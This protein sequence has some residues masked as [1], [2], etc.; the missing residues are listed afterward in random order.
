MKS[1]IKDT[2]KKQRIISTKKKAKYN[3]KK[4]SSIVLYFTNQSDYNNNYK[5]A[6]NRYMTQFSIEQASNVLVWIAKQNRFKI[7]K[8]YF[9]QYQLDIIEVDIEDRYRTRTN[10]I[11]MS[12]N[13]C[14]VLD[15]SNIPPEAKYVND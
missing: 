8:G 11:M 5:K 14:L 7:T 3:Y 1:L 9:T 4:G 12:F 6:I 10:K 15:V 2:P 13:N